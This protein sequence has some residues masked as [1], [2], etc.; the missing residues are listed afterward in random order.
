MS[1]DRDDSGGEPHVLGEGKIIRATEKAV[2]AK[3]GDKEIWIPKSCIH[4]DSEAFS[5]NENA[6]EGSIVVLA[7]WAERNGHA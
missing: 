3:I 2:L 1:R 5:D 7:W 4:D 6:N